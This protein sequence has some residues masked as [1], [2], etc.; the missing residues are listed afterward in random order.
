MT[1]DYILNDG[2][3]EKYYLSEPGEIVEIP[4]GTKTIGPD[5][6]WNRYDIDD[7]GLGVSKIIIP[8]SV[9]T[10]DSGAFV[11]LEWVEE[12]I[13]VAEGNP[14][15]RADGRMLFSKDGKR[16]IAV[17]PLDKYETGNELQ[18]PDG[19]EFVEECALFNAQYT[20]VVYP[21]SVK[22]VKDQ[23]YHPDF[24]GDSMG[25][26]TYRVVVFHN[27]DTVFPGEEKDV[28][29]YSTVIKAPADSAAIE[30]AKENG[31]EYEEI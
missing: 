12:G 27:K 31:V 25:A 8:E 30:Y 15:L 23:Y 6:L 13:E 3:L 19:V 26:Q 17:L 14:Y 21:Q 1:E 10:V 2:V 18:I 4:E 20:D 9:E 24:G 11:Y 16:L 28:L 22:T 5:F 29:Q 7:V